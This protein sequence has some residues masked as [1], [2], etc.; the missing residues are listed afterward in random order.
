M[1]ELVPGQIFATDFRVVR[2]L[3]KGGMGSVYVVEQVSTEL[4]RAL[5]L[6]HPELVRDPRLRQRFEQEARIGGHIASDH[7]A[8]VISAGVD[9]ATGT[10]WLAME[11]L[12]GETLA[13]WIVRRRT[14]LGELFEIFGQLC[15]GLGAAHTQG[16]V[17]R[18]LKPENIFVALPRQA[19]LPFFIKVLDFGIAKMASQHGAGAT[20]TSMG[21]PLWMAPEQT[22]NGRVGPPTD[23]WALGLI[24]FALL[25][26]RPYWTRATREDT[27]LPALMREI[28]FEPMVKASVRA[29]EYGI[30]LEAEQ[31]F[32]AWFARAAAR[33]Q[34]A[35]FAN[36]SEAY[37]A[38]TSWLGRPGVPMAVAP[39]MASYPIEPVPPTIGTGTHLPGAGFSASNAAYP[40][41]AP[42]FPGVTERGISETVREPPSK[43]GRAL[44]AV[45]VATLVLVGAGAFG[46]M[47]LRAEPSAAVAPAAT[48]ATAPA[49]ST[50]PAAPAATVAAPASTCSAAPDQA[51]IRAALKDAESRAH[52]GCRPPGAGKNTGT[53]T[54]A[55]APSG[56][57]SATIDGALGAS[58]GGR[59]LTNFLTSARV[60]CFTGEPVK[61]RKSITLE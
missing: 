46:W 54:I 41:P 21:T 39:A 53:V 52:A 16:I 47:K 10:P 27:T 1:L 61:L 7:I 56:Q 49:V 40:A 14:S 42:A 32:D 51:A 15:H 20:T 3:S 9:A 33:D 55:V 59:C 25:T 22:E 28:L 37:A 60:A 36:A 44:G 2:P 18:D 17:H 8:Q 48:D 29:R 34:A 6:M 43:G 26:Q 45:A 50:A 38:L 12:Q 13:E 23:V 30:V 24:A 31:A 57:V 19:G 5:K 11:L 35:R 4:Q 58:E